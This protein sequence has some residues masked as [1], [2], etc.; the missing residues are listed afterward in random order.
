MQVQQSRFHSVCAPYA[1]D[2]RVGHADCLA[3]GTADRPADS[4]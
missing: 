4:L 2:P 3:S 1:Q